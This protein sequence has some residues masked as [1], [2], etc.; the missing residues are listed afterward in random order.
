[1]DIETLIRI[2]TTRRVPADTLT[3]RRP[4]QHG[5][6]KE[7]K[8]Q[9]NKG[10]IKTGWVM[11]HIEQL[12]FRPFEITRPEIFQPSC[13][14][15][16]CTSDCENC[17]RLRHDV[18]GV[19]VIRTAHAGKLHD[20][21]YWRASPVRGTC[22]NCDRIDLVRRYIVTSRLASW[23]GNPNRVPAITD[24]GLWHSNCFQGRFGMRGSM[25][26]VQGGGIETSRR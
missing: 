4:D 9:S 17:R 12:G 18:R 25:R 3:V 20:V 10:N 24:L 6:I 11:Y 26:P 2:V 13:G 16:T 21:T 22:T 19:P 8:A 23:R 7:I 1:M 15:D 5:A 14:L